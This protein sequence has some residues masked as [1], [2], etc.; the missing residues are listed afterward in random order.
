MIK[1]FGV[2]QGRLLKPVNKK[3]QSFPT[4]KWFKEFKLIKD[5]NLKHLEWTLDDK[6]LEKNPLLSKKGQIQIKNLCKQNNITIN[7][8][9]GD[10]FMQKPF[11][12][13]K[14]DE[15]KKLLIKLKKIINGASKIKTKFIVIP[16]VDNGK[17]KNKNQRKTLIKDLKKMENL[18]AEKRVQILFETDF[19]A[20]ENL[21]FI[22]NFNK[23]LFGINYDIGNSASLNYNPIEEFGL[24]SAYIKNIHIKDRKKFGKT[25]PLGKGNAK[26]NLIS[27]LCKKYNYKGKFILQ[28][29]R[30]KSGDEINTLRNYLKFLKRYF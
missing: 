28:C 9:T 4:K 30:K 8:V 18:L 29:A 14:G 25:V 21:K 13:K 11:W 22:K 27:K 2:M 5:L 23:K 16:L 3:I 6:N 19:S 24:F 15:K 20:V 10:C 17:I 26:F 12:K 7:S 1:N